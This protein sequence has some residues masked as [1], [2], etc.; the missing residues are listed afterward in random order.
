MNRREH[1]GHEQSQHGER[2]DH[3][4][5]ERDAQPGDFAELGLQG[6]QVEQRLSRVRV[7]AVAGVDD[8][9]LKR[10]GESVR[11]ARFGVTRD[12]YAHAHCGK[13]YRRIG[14]RLTLP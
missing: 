8:V 5:D 9:T 1:G 4:A 3:V 2:A 7:A 14:N 10:F 12:D 13:R 6:E 11:K